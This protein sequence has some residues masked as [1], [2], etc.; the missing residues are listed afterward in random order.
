MKSVAYAFASF[1]TFL[2]LASCGAEDV[3]N[4]PATDGIELQSQ[5]LSSAAAKEK[6]KCKGKKPKN[7]GEPCGCGG[8]FRCDGTCSAVFPINYG[9]AC[10]CGGTVQCNGSCSQPEPINPE[11][12]ACGGQVRCDGTCSVAVPID[13]GKVCGCG[14]TVDCFGFCRNGACPI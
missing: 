3:A 8:F 9:Q 7:V 11:C 4:D 14:G 10:G 13:Y 12:A 1:V 2:T 6:L 5:E